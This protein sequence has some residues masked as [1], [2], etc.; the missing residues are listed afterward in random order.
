VEPRATALRD[1]GWHSLGLD[2]RILA[3]WAVAESESRPGVAYHVRAYIDIALNKIVKYTCECPD[4]L[5]RGAKRPC[6][7]ILKLHLHLHKL[8]NQA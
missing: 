1:L 7:H 2:E 6:K 3:V 5:F 8:L 4:Y